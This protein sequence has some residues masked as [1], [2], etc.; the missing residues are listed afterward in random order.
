M[1]SLYIKGGNNMIYRKKY[2]EG[3]YYAKVS[4]V[5]SDDKNLSSCAT[6]ILTFMLGK[7]DSWEFKFYH[8]EDRF[9]DIKEGRIR[10]CLKE[11]ETL[12]YLSRSKYNKGTRFD[13]VWNVYEV[14]QLNPNFDNNTTIDF[15]EFIKLYK[16]LYKSK[17]KK[18]HK[19]IIFVNYKDLFN[20]YNSEVDLKRNDWESLILDFLSKSKFK[21]TDYSLSLFMSGDIIKVGLVR[22][23]KEAPF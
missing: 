9:S 13:W 7:G 1:N 15:N 23:G 14:P 3:D 4:S 20:E 2:Q 8:I 6:G 19:Q 10:K 18:E 5:T 16:K 17:L 12:G 11:L 21:N 22:I